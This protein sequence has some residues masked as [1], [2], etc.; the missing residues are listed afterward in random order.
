MCLHHLV[1]EQVATLPA[2][3]F[4]AP[5]HD[6]WT[7]N[8]FHALGDRDCAMFDFVRSVLGAA[9]AALSAAGQGA[10]VIGPSTALD[11]GLAAL[12][13]GTLPAHTQVPYMGRHTSTRDVDER[14][15]YRVKCHRG[16]IDGSVVASAA[17]VVNS[18]AEL[19]NVQFEHRGHV[20]WAALTRV[21]TSEELWAD[22]VV[23]AGDRAR[24]HPVWTH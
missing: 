18:D 12:V 5:P 1:T 17:A 8:L 4:A 7:S 11:N 20:V 24:A 22:Y 19:Q 2:T 10:V 9:D 14:N 6:D 15:V 3:L 21:A 16:V 23:D 13:L